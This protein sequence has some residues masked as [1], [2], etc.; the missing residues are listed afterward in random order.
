[1]NIYT[2]SPF[3]LLYR[4]SVLAAPYDVKIDPIYVDVVAGSSFQ[5]TCTAKG[6]PT[7][8]FAWY[9]SD[10]MIQTGASL[11]VT[12]SVSSDDGLYTCVATNSLGMAQAT[13]DANVRCKLHFKW[14]RPHLIVML[15]IN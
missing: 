1:M 11:T 9:Y 5:A 10:T 4:T 8:S 2:I 3:F 7:P 15:Y 13:M 6:D 12:S 14:H